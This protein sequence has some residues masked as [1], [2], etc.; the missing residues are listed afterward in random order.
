MDREGLS[1][2]VIA[3]G[4]SSR[5]GQDK[6]WLEYD[7]ASMLEWLLRKAQRQDFACKYL[8]VERETKQLLALAQQ[9]GFQL[10]ADEQA[11]MGPLEGLRRG[12]SA[13]PTQYGL[14]VSCDMPF[15]SFSAVK[16]LLAELDGGEGSEAVLAETAGRRQPLAAVYHRDCARHFAQALAVGQRKIGT[17][18]AKVRQKLIP[19]PRVNCFFN[20]NTPAD[21]QLARG[22]LANS[23]REIPLVTVSAPVSNTGKTTFIER[24]I[25]RLR[26]CGIRVGVVKGDCHGYQVDVAGKDS[27][28]FARAGADA[29][30]VVSPAGYFIERRTEKRASLL[31][32]AAKLEGVDLVLIESRNHGAMPKLSLWRGLGEPVIDAETVALFSSDLAVQAADGAVH[33]YAIDDMAQAEKIVCF[34]M[35]RDF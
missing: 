20:A 27:W 6:R 12:L 34:L 35:G 28:R 33:R 22:R 23:R 14:A 17:V 21:M 11:G 24:L 29:V 26:A 32:V 8:C 4:K 3:G 15:F 18:L 19:V 16:P 31:A 13:M 10:L 30:A 1:L 5:M 2:L 9:Y 25:P 7:G